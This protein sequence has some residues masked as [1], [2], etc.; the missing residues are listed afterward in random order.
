[1]IVVDANVIIYLFV[2]SPHQDAVCNLLGS[3]SEWHAPTLWRSECR[4]ALTMYYRKNLISSKA[5]L[6]ITSAAERL[7]QERE[8]FLDSEEV[9]KLA[10]NS[11]CSAYDCEYAALAIKL[12]TKLYTFD[13]KLLSSFP[14]VALKPE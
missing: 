12:K 3:K 5:I 7:M 1:M 9:L 4:N 11:T 10:L 8:H 2:E 13:K 14:K 6:E